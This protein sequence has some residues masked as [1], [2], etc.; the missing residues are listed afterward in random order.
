MKFVSVSQ[1]LRLALCC[2]S[3]SVS[4]LFTAPGLIC[5]TW[6]KRSGG[7]WREASCLLWTGQGSSAGVPGCCRHSAAR[8][9]FSPFLWFCE[10]GGLGRNIHCYPACSPGPLCAAWAAG[11][12]LTICARPVSLIHHLCHLW[13]ALIRGVS[14]TSFFAGLGL[15]TLKVS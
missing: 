7:G 8:L 15:L 6:E 4:G 11:P 3:G 5:L 9:C 12:P 10:Y 14:H 13:G 2:L 1:L